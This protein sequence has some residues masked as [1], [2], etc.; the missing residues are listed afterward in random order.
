MRHKTTF[1]LGI[2]LLLVLLAYFVTFK[3]NFNEV[4]VLTTFGKA[5]PDAVYEGGE[6]AGGVLGNLH[7]KWPPPIQMTTSYD[8]CVK[9]L[10]DRLEEQQTADKKSIIGE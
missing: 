6:D 2:A 3:V 1:F 5:G 10:E 9:I 7:F 4:V 8:Q